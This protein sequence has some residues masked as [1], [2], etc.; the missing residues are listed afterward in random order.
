[1]E[2]GCTGR[3]RGGSHL[4]VGRIVILIHMQ[5]IV[6]GSEASGGAASVLKHAG[7]VA[8][9]MLETSTGRGT[10]PTLGHD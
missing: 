9:L 3:R 4:Y 7:D 10:P 6:L 1:M 5:V 8:T 2:N